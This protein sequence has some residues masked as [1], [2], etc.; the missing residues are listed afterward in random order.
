MPLTIFFTTPF[1]G[2]GAFPITCS[3]GLPLGC[4]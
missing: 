3:G 4:L 2:T 1:D